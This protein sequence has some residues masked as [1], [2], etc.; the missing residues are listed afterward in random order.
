MSLKYYEAANKIR[1]PNPKASYYADYAAILDFSFD[2]APNVVY[3]EI[4]YEQTYGENDFAFINKVR[5]DT[6]LNYNTGIIL[7]DDYKTFIFA[8]DFPVE[9]YYGMKFRWKG[10]YWL[11][12]NTNTYASMTVTAEVRRCNN[13]LRF[14]DANG[15]KVYEPCIMDYTLRFANN[16]DTMEIIVGNGEQKV[17]CQRNKNTVTIKANDRFL[18][19][20]PEQRVAFRLY[21]GGT[22]NYMNGV[23]MDDNSPTITEFYID[24]YE[25]N[26]LFD[27]IE[28]G[29]ANAY[30]NE[31]TI[32]IGDT[33]NAL[34]INESE[35]LEATAYKG[36][37]ELT[38]ANIVWSTSDEAVVEIVDNIATAKALGDVVLTATIEGTDITSSVNIS[39]VEEPT[40]DVYEL[41]VDP[42]ITYVLQNK[43]QQFS[44]NLYKNGIKQADEVT[45]TDLSTGIPSGKY[46][47]TGGDNNTFT[48]TNQGMYMGSPVI[49]RCSCGDYSVELS[50]KLRGLY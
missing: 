27:D 26:P 14:F 45:F 20:T 36:S 50:I 46:V 33:I 22:K 34:N 29:F 16:E 10:S 2:N 18:F 13:V 17:W 37:K 6:V 43:S 39:V 41:I 48:L 12:I 25:I 4:E 40:E 49:V 31:V 44:V 23:T 8:P 38:E 19:G 11:V 30:L 32:N 47:I 15:Q 35:V 24:H 21:G 1:Q 28:N 42:N 5:V 7:G 3:D 9:P